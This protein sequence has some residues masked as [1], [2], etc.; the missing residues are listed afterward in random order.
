[1]LGA[2]LI[3]ALLR[4]RLSALALATA[5]LAG[6]AVVAFAV[7]AHRRIRKS[8]T[9]QLAAGLGLAMCVAPIELAGGV[10]PSSVASALVA[11]SVVFLSS[12]LVVRAAFNRSARHAAVRSESLHAASFGIA[13]LMAALFWLSRH[14]VEAFACAMVA[15][16]CAIFLASHPTVK[17]LKPLGL[18]LGGLVLMSSLALTL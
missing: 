13:L 5:S 4:A 1:M 18:T 8:A 6:P 12:A 15:S 17:Q 3:S 16:V 9:A 11:R 10:S 2:S 7:V 14:V